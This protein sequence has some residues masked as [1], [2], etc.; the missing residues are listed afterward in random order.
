VIGRRA[1]RSAVLLAFAIGCAGMPGA[2]PRPVASAIFD[3]AA[4]FTRYSTWAWKPSVRPLTGEPRV[5]NPF[6]HDRIQR[7]VATE[8]MA[9]GLVQ[10]TPAAAD[11][12]LL[13]RLALTEDFQ[14]GALEASGDFP[15]AIDPGVR[16]ALF[17]RVVKRGSMVLDMFDPKRGTVVWRGFVE[18]EVSSFQNPDAQLPAVQSSVRALLADYPPPPVQRGE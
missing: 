2:R 3:P 12:L 10:T 16:S 1:L 13:Y 17:G 8:L 6:L 15:P 7:A 14:P 4:D 9:R 11:L 18:R 5:D